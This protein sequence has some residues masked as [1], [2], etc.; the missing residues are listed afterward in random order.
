MVSGGD[1]KLYARVEDG[2][3]TFIRWIYSHVEYKLTTS[4]L[5]VTCMTNFYNY[6]S[7]EQLVNVNLPRLKIIKKQR[8]RKPGLRNPSLYD[9]NPIT[10]LQEKFRA[11]PRPTEGAELLMHVR[12]YLIV[13]ALK[14]TGMRRSELCSIEWG[15]INLRWCKIT[16]IGKG[17]KQRVV[18]FSNETKRAMFDYRE[19]FALIQPKRYALPVP[20][21]KRPL[22][23]GHRST[24]VGFRHVR[25][26]M[27]WVAIRRRATQFLGAEAAEK[28]WPHL[29]RHSFVTKI[30]EK[31]DN[32]E[33]A[34][35]LVGHASIV[36]TA[37]YAHPKHLDTAYDVIFNQGVRK[38]KDYIRLMEEA[39]KG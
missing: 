31:T 25:T 7:A 39:K 21:H 11:A 24:D 35:E 4:I 38:R 6:M 37:R 32:L 10:E 9:F 16:V 28:V 2:Y 18:R 3:S 33:M 26:G 19:T 20:L 15:D 30:L 27:I 34:Q 5:R 8:T 17:D 29:F 14:D 12:D 22:I 36:M 1:G 13:V 23:L